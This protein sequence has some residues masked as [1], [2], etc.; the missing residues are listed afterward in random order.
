MLP[1]SPPAGMKCTPSQTKLYCAWDQYDY[2]LLL[3]GNSLLRHGKL[4]AACYCSPPCGYGAWGLA[5]IASLLGETAIT[6]LD[7]IPYLLS[8]DVACSA[9]LMR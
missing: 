9:D 6:T 7:Y 4:A 1:W 2:P 3:A 8:L 5:S